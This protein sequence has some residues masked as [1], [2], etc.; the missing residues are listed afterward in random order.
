MK[1]KTLFI[2]LAFIAL[3]FT[4][5]SQSIGRQVIGCTGKISTANSKIT[6]TVG[7]SILTTAESAETRLTQG[8]QQPAGDMILAE[9]TVILPNCFQPESG[10]IDLNITGC[11]GIF[12]VMWNTGDTTAILDNLMPGTYYYTI[13]SG[14]CNLTDSVSLTLEEECE[15]TYPNLVTPNADGTNDILVIPQFYLESNLDNDVSI[16]NRWGQL[17]WSESN[18]DNTEVFWHGANS[19]GDE[20]PS[21]TYFYVITHLEEKHSG[22]IELLR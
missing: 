8:F 4:S 10:Q 20:L 13:T 19:S 12:S 7:P 14:S 17:V 11:S 21:G 1:L 22:Y 6:A 5:Y 3:S 18:Y 9:S 2:I 16:Y 15:D